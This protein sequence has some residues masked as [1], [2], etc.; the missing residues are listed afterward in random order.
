MAGRSLSLNICPQEFRV[1]E[2]GNL[3][4][5][6]GVVLDLVVRFVKD[7][8]KPSIVV[9]LDLASELT[10]LARLPPHRGRARIARSFFPI[11]DFVGYADNTA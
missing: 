7:P 8:G 10:E 1:N 9:A 4:P 3:V 5:D 6:L 11:F 2:R